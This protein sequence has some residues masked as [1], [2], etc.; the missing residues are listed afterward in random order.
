M[1]RKSQRAKLEL[2]QDQR[3]ELLKL[4]Q[5]RTAPVREAQRAAVLIRYADG[6]TISSIKQELQVSRPTIY[7][8]IDKVLAAGIE[9][10]L[11][12]KYHKPK[13]PD[14]TEEAKTWVVNL[15]CTKPKDHGYA[16]EM[17]TLSHLAKHTR[18]HAPAAG[19]ECLQRA[20]KATI[21]RILKSQPLRPH[22]IRYYLEKRD[23]EFA[24]KMCEVLVVY[25][26]VNAQ[27]TN[28]TPIL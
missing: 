20:A 18:M 13:E 24:R 28:R 15:A 27:R 22:K 12:D 10:S 21:H 23:T 5:S 3:Q 8:C 25:K 6:K 26:E 14:I 17:W 11:K 2:A 4:S 19:Y 16:A 9:T 7:K 1:P